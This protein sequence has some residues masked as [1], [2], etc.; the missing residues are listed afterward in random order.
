MNNVTAPA[1]ELARTL[2][3]QALLNVRKARISGDH[4][5]SIRAESRMNALLDQHRRRTPRTLQQA[6]R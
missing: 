1:T 3:Y 6:S 4:V 5:G 2:V